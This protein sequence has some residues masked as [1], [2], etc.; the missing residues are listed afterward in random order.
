MGE[1]PQ[2]VDIG[3][4]DIVATGQAC[5]Q[6][7]RCRAAAEITLLI[8][9][10]IQCHI[11]RR[12]VVDQTREGKSASFDAQH[13]ARRHV[14][15]DPPRGG[16]PGI[17]TRIERRKRDAVYDTVEHHRPGDRDVMPQRQLRQAG[18]DCVDLR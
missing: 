10:L 1:W 6:P 7:I 12:V 17:F 15:L 13:I 14:A 5:A 8:E 4:D 9:K 3:E 11:G 18:R 2:A 16:H